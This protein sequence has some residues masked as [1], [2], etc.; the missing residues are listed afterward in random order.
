MTVHYSGEYYDY[1]EVE[2]KYFRQFKKQSIT[3][4]ID[5]MID[6]IYGIIDT[7]YYCDWCIEGSMYIPKYKLPLEYIKKRWSINKTMK[8]MDVFKKQFPHE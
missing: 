4:S 6:D 5:E 7:N 8:A 3:K 2:Q 1:Q